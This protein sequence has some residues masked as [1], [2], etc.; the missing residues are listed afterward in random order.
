MTTAGFE[1]GGEPWAKEYWQPLEAG[2]GKERHSS[3][4]PP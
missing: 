1:D 4:E 2:R 3:L